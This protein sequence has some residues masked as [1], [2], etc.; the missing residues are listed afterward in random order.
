TGVLID[1]SNN[2]RFSGV[3]VSNLSTAGTSECFT[4]SGSAR[5]TVNHI[6]TINCIDSSS[7]NGYGIHF[8]ATSNRGT[9]VQALA[10]G[11]DHAGIWLDS[12]SY[13][14]LSQVATSRNGYGIYGSGTTNN[15]LLTDNILVGNN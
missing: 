1:G 6:S 5:M 13:T 9:I 4:V 11:A 15:T 10:A 3:Q 12:A 2:V 8:Y 14:L 7:S